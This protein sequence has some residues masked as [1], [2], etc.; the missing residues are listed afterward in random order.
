MLNFR[1]HFIGRAGMFFGATCRL[2]WLISLRSKYVFDES[3]QVFLVTGGTFV[4]A[5]QF[6]VEQQASLLWDSK[7][8]QFSL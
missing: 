6:F 8:G 5:D 1:K 7:P 2:S 4:W 3:S